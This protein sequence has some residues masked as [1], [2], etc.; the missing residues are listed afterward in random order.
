MIKAKQPVSHFIGP[1]LPGA[2]EV[3]PIPAITRD[4]N[5]DFAW[6]LVDSFI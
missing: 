1:G 4:R 2:Q 5:L 3:G 6:L